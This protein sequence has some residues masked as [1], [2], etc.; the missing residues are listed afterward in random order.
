MNVSRGPRRDI[1][2]LASPLCTL[3]ALPFAREFEIYIYESIH[4][5]LKRQYMFW[6]CTERKWMNKNITWDNRLCS[7]C[8]PPSRSRRPRSPARCRTPR[9]WG[10]R[11][12]TSSPRRTG[13]TCPWCVGGS[14]RTAG[15]D[16]LHPPHPPSEQGSRQQGA[17]WDCRGEERYL[18]YNSYY[19]L[20]SWYKRFQ[21]F[22][23]KF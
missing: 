3:L 2:P 1:T 7:R 8:V 16:P 4:V 20:F 22:W 6:F 10:R 12:A 18:L 9:T 13:R 17:H 19:V 11:S 23:I 14:P 21:I 5:I 15:P